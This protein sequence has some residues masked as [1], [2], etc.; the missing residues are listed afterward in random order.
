MFVCMLELQGI[1][2]PQE[3]ATVE[4]LLVKGILHDKLSELVNTQGISSI[5][6]IDPVAGHNDNAH[7]F[8]SKALEA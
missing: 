8:T 1:H 3:D 2:R 6:N 4:K 7:T 5:V